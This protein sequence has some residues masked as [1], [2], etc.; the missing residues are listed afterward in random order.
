[1][2]LWHFHSPYRLHECKYVPVSACFISKENKDN[3]VFIPVLRPLPPMFLALLF[4]CQILLF[5]ENGIIIEQTSDRINIHQMTYQVNL[6]NHVFDSW[7]GNLV[8]VG[9][10]DQIDIV[11]A[12]DDN[13]GDRTQIA[14]TERLYL[15]TE[16]VVLR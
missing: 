3:T 4:F 13:I 9:S 6:F 15:Q 14:S 8:A 5:I 16:N 12:C 2:Q 10:F 11:T 1:M 7:N